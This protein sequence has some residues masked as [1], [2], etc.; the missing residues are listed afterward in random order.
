MF[1]CLHTITFMY[2]IFT[3]NKL[4]FLLTQFRG[5]SSVL[6]SQ[7]KNHLLLMFLLCTFFECVCKE[8]TYHFFF[9]FSS[10]FLRC[11]VG[12]GVFHKGGYLVLLVS[13]GWIPCSPRKFDLC[14]DFAIL[15]AF[16]GIFM[17]LPLMSVIAL[18]KVESTTREYCVS[19]CQEQFLCE[20]PTPKNS[21]KTSLMGISIVSSLIIHILAILNTNKGI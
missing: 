16:I 8:S 12:D 5:T 1:F 2:N 13:S 18:L 7:R 9:I 10:N 14:L 11:D 4:V 15:M 3:H 20:F 17:W 21:P 6:K 19:M